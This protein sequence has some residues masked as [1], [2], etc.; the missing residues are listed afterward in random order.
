MAATLGQGTTART[1]TTPGHLSHSRHVFQRSS[2]PATDSLLHV[3][4][5]TARDHHSRLSRYHRTVQARPSSSSTRGA[6]P[7]SLV[8]LRVQ[9][10]YRWSCPRRS[11]TRSTRSQS[12]PQCRSSRS[13]TS[14]LVSSVPPPML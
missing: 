6:Y 13:V 11:A 14:R 2:L 1:G 4:R 12:A 10:E 7:S 5:V 8:I 9:S 3:S